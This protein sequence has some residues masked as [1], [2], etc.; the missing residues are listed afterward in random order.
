MKTNFY[1]ILFTVLTGFSYS[2]GFWTQKNDF[3]GNARS[4]GI[5]FSLGGFGYYGTGNHVGGSVE[6]NDF[7][8]YDA[9]SDTWL[10]RANLPN[11]MQAAAGSSTSGFGYVGLGWWSSNAHANYFK[12]NPITN[13]WS[14]VAN[15]IGNL[16]NDGVSVG[17]NGIV[18]SGLGGQPYSGN[19]WDDWKAYNETTNTWSSLAIF[20]GADRRNLT[21]FVV[22]N[23]IYAG[24]G[25]P[26][27]GATGNDFYKYDVSLNTWS[28]IASCPSTTTTYTRNSSFVLNGKAYLALSDG[29]WEYN[30][31]TNTWT[32]YPMPFTTGVD[33]A[34]SLNGKGYIIKSGSKQVWEW[35]ACSNTTSILSE[36]VCNSYVA[37]DNQVYSISGTY[38]AIIP[39][40]TGCDSTITIN[41]TVKNSSSSTQIIEAC[42]SFSAPDGQVYTSDG[43]Y[44]A[45]IPNAVGCDSTITIDLTINQPS[46]SF[47]NEHACGNYIAPDGQTYSNSGVYT[48]IIS[49]Q[50][51]C[52][53]TITIDLSVTNIDNSVTV[54]G[55][56]LSANQLVAGYQWLDCDNGNQEMVG[57][58]NQHFEATQNGQFAVEITYDGCVDTSECVL[59]DYVGLESI[60]RP[61]ISFY[62]N[63]ATL[64]LI[65]DHL[66]VNTSVNI[67]DLQ[68]KTVL[69]SILTQQIDISLLTNGFYFLQILNNTEVLF[70][71]KFMKY[72]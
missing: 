68:G 4:R 39:N 50:A 54:D 69:R 7:W 51:G 62:S 47:I 72:E 52:D 2:Q 25:Q 22:N 40:S 70:N 60:E 64:N 35:T 65:Y 38:T 57:E 32:S 3:P 44:T 8:R 6:T 19:C 11:G 58:F 9:S 17:H 67:L 59:I 46:T 27:G 12:Y 14:S 71:E 43:I 41:L 26:E 24:G 13:S 21:A 31:L 36:T 63:E 42:E 61:N 28:P 45:I 34:F 56:L 53:S 30:P 1:I 33:G 23:E 5:C 10:Q 49:N 55:L 37:P 29:L 15:Y 20:P 16:T 18:Y 48:A 66:P